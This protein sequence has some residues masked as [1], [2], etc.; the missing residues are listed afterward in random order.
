MEK[1][2]YVGEELDKAERRNTPIDKKENF[3]SININALDYGY[4]V[5]VGCK[6]FS[7]ETKERLIK[8][9]TKYLEKP[10]ELEKEYKEKNNLIFQDK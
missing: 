5:H 10:S 9:L 2:I 7:F 4:N 8:Y 3:Y 6:T 1:E